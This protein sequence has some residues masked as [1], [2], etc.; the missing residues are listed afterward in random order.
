[1][2]H[3]IWEGTK[4]HKKLQSGVGE[5]GAQISIINPNTEGKRSWE[6]G[7]KLQKQS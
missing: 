5:G 7:S 3:G 4:I 1:M 6:A 2:G